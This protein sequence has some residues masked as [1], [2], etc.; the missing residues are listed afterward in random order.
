M[1]MDLSVGINFIRTELDLGLTFASV[2]AN[3]SDEEKF[4]RNRENARRAC[5]T[6]RHFVDRFCLSDN[7]FADIHDKIGALEHTLQML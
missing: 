2:A 5:Q 6:A 3:A 7:E 4:R 1:S